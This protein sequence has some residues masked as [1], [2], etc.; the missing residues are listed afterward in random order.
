MSNLIFPA[1]ARAGL[2]VS[3]V[4]HE[5]GHALIYRVFFEKAAGILRSAPVD[6]VSGV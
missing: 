4:I 1:L 2:F 3:I 5:L 6:T